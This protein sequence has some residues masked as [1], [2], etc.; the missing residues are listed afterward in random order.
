MFVHEL[1]RRYASIKPEVMEYDQSEGANLAKTYDITTQ[2][3]LLVLRNDGQLIQMW[4]GLPLPL[5]DEVASY[6]LEQ[7]T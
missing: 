3:S 7:G 1:E 6:A 5:I 4:Q 2:P